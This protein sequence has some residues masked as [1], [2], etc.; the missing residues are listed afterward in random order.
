M[1]PDS[2]W[3]RCCRPIVCSV[4]ALYT[5]ACT[6][7]FSGGDCTAVGVSGITVTVIDAITKGAPSATPMVR[8]EEGSYV[9]EHAVPFPRSDP[10][11]YTTADERPGT[12]RVVV[13]AVG[14]QDYVLDKIR[15]VRAGR[16][17]ALKGVRIT[18]PLVRSTAR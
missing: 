15:V 9:E 11:L 2:F 8:I 14:Y 4:A 7:P 3:P 18:A 12:Y 10:P 16:C 13:R 6:N 5:V 17:N 1:N